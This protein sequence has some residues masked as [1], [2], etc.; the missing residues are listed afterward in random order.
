MW[1]GIFRISALCVLNA[2]RRTCPSHIGHNKGTPRNVVGKVRGCLQH[3]ARNTENHFRAVNATREVRKALRLLDRLEMQLT[4]Q[5]DARKFRSC[6][7]CPSMPACQ[8]RR[9]PPGRCRIHRYRL[10]RTKTV[11]IMRAARFGASA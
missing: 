2:D 4:L 10:L 7:Q 8:Q 1:R 3:I 6:V 9:I 11:K 5:P